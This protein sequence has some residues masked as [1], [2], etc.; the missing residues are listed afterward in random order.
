MLRC[1]LMIFCLTF[2]ACRAT[3]GVIAPVSPAG[4]AEVWVDGAGR[5]AG[6][7]SRARPFASL[8]EALARGAGAT[9][10]R[11]H[12]GPGRYP[13]PFGLPAGVELVG[14]G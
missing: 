5:G 11:V 8:S 7:G 4:P 6:D 1:L 9:S 10:L 3:A 12:L 14:A 2:P 13:G